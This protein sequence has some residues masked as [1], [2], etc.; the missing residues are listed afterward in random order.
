ME[1][2]KPR[3]GFYPVDDNGS[4]QSDSASEFSEKDVVNPNLMELQEKSFKDRYEIMKRAYESRIE[5]LSQVI[6]ETC[7]QLVSDEVLANMKGDPTSQDYIPAHLQE[8]LSTHVHS[9]RERYIHDLVTRV[10]SLE[11][12]GKQSADKV[13]VQERKI[14]HLESDVSKGRKAEV[15]LDALFNK[16]GELE[17]KHEELIHNSA[18]L[19]NQMTARI[20]Q[21]EKEK[22][23][24]LV[25]ID[26]LNNAVIEK[27]TELEV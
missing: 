21:L 10:A 25:N 7:Q 14:R 5:Q 22:G 11:S 12:S 20:E 17:R 27:G 24:L 4:I 26:N 13:Q 2:L 1:S 16:F 15:A 18:N 8:L 6:Q 19:E 9:E 23:G 3:R